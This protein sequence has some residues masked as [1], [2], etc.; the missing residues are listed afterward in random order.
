M[1][2]LDRNRRA[3][4][5]NV[6][7]EAI[8]DIAIGSFS[9]FLVTLDLYGYSPTT[10]CQHQIE[11]VAGEIN[12]LGIVNSGAPR[13]GDRNRLGTPTGLKGSLFKCQQ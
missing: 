7:G 6:P 8:K 3:R 5:F 1:S 12:V 4:C 9:I 10:T 2:V 11:I 13:I